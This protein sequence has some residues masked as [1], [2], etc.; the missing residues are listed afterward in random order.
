M[1]PTKKVPP[2]R[3]EEKA[4]DYIADLEAMVGRVPRTCV[5]VVD[6]LKELTM[7][8]KQKKETLLRAEGSNKLVRQIMD[9]IK[10]Y[11]T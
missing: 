10:E 11:D 1:P 8:L 7:S 2:Q 3:H 5:G 4:P 9:D 6:R